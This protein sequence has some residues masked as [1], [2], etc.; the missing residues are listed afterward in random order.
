MKKLLVVLLAAALLVSVACGFAEAPDGGMAIANP[1]Q[2]TTPEEL[3]QVYGYRFVVPDDADDVVYRVDDELQMAEMRFSLDGAL[4]IAR[5]APCDFEDI[6]GMFY[7]WEYE[8]SAKGEFTRRW[9]QEKLMKVH[10]G[11]DTVEVFLWFD[12]VPGLTYSL[13]TKAPDL[14]GFDII[15]IAEAVW[16]QAQGEA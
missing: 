7:D 6:S 2:E 15:A 3:D 14:D 8:E 11:E 10:D 1:W 4:M 9:F 12:I 13:S 5:V 16:H